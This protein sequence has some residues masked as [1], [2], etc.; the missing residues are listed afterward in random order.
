MISENSKGYKAA[1][2]L[3]KTVIP[4]VC[5]K[6]VQKKLTEKEEEIINNKELINY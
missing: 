6:V 1:A 5:N 4:Y 3:A 2:W